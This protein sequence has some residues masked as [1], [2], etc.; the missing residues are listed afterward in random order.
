MKLK[1][2]ITPLIILV[3]IIATIMVIL[4]MAFETRDKFFELKEA[5]NKL[6][7]ISEKMEKSDLL[8]QE[9]AAN[10]QKQNVL[11]KYL[12]ME[13]QEE[14]VINNLNAV[15]ASAGVA[16]TEMEILPEKTTGTGK[17]DKTVK[18]NLTSEEVEMA[19]QKQEEGN[20]S[21]AGLLNAVN[22]K[23]SVIGSYD[24]LKN[25]V[26]K[27]GQMQRANQLASLKIFQPTAQEKNPSNNLQ[28]TVELSFSYLKK[29]T[30][31]NVSSR[32]LESGKFEMLPVVDQ[33]E[34]NLKT[35][36]AEI[37]LGAAGKANPFLP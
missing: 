7:E 37:N 19:G 17:A 8:K 3:A 10:A 35:E 36:F 14:D 27:I 33:I 16:I 21:E 34:N 20:R 13:K 15:A 25:A 24:N 30:L 28:A 4:P 2:L 22:V 32:I 18:A 12:P 29:V 11:L 31:A 1:I 26:G 5:R 23:L 9:L 6:A